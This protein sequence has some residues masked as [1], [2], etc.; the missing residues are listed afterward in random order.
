MSEYNNFRIT[1]ELD[2]F[3]TND[4]VNVQFNKWGSGTSSWSPSV[5]YNAI[6]DTYTPKLS[7]SKITLTFNLKLE[8]TNQGTGS[9]NIKFALYV[10][11]A[12]YGD[13]FIMLNDSTGAGGGNSSTGSIVYN[14]TNLNTKTFQLRVIQ[15][16]GGT[17]LGANNWY[18]VEIKE[19]KL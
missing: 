14:N 15:N 9:R 10:D 16:D 17:R 7:S 8:A 19:T 13:D 5:G 18:S 1:N 3:V 2:N 11:N 12:L 6:T 4:L